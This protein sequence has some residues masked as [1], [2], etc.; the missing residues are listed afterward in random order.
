MLLKLNSE[1]AG[2]GTGDT[3]DGEEA[4]A[5]PPRSHSVHTGGIS[6]GGFGTLVECTHHSHGIF[7]LTQNPRYKPVQLARAD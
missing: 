7:S 5:S 3:G 6:V 1:K 2:W 4:R